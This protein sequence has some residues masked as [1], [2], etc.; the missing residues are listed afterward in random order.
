M[1]LLALLELAFFFK[2]VSDLA[3]RFASAP[4]SFLAETHIHVHSYNLPLQLSL[5]QP[6]HC[7]LRAFLVLVFN[8]AEPARG[9]VL[10]VQAHFD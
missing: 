8:K 4:L 2:V 1:A 6:L 7:F 3:P 9:L 5:S 10:A